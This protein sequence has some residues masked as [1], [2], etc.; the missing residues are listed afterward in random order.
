MLHLV[1]S[2]KNR[3]P[4]ITPD[5][6]RRLYAYTAGILNS[7]KCPAIQIGGVADHI[8]ILMC[9]SRTECV[10]D[11]VEAIKTGSSKW[12]KGQGSPNFAW[13]HGYASLSIGRTEKEMIV[14]YILRQEEHHHHRSFQEQYRALL[15]EHE[16]DYDERYMWD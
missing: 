15:D 14:G 12:A 5:L 9:L 8:H 1:F 10:A 7:E 4:F 13:Q 3:T 6:Q 16:V 2:T 11:I